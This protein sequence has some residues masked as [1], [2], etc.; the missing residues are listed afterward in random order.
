MGFIDRLRNN[1]TLAIFENAQTRI[2]DWKM[3]F[4]NYRV[5]LNRC[6]EVEKY[7]LHANAHD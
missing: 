2:S 1:K 6:S 4:K 5:K 7:H 3:D